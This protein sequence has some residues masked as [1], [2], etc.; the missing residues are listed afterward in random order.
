MECNFRNNCLIRTSLPTASTPTG[1]VLVPN[2][3]PSPWN[4][5]ISTRLFQPSRDRATAPSV[6]KGFKR[7]R[8]G[9]DRIESLDPESSKGKGGDTDLVQH[10]D[11]FFGEHQLIIADSVKILNAR[12]QFVAGFVIETDGRTICLL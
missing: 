12:H 9:F 8:P 7:S 11:Q 6:V 3:C 1:K 5:Q 4:V 2:M 10:L